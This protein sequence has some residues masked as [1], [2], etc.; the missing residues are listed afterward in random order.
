MS[1]LLCSPATHEAI[2]IGVIAFISANASWAHQPSCYFFRTLSLKDPDQSHASVLAWIKRGSLGKCAITKW[3]H[4]FAVGTHKQIK[5][6]KKTKKKHAY[7]N[8]GINYFLSKLFGSQWR[9]L[10]EIK[11]KRDSV[12]CKYFIWHIMDTYLVGLR[13]A[14]VTLTRMFWH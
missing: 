1:A 5:T 2:H 12:A 4:K 14:F 10:E 11:A 13:K 3:L 7:T 6:K 9:V 8:F